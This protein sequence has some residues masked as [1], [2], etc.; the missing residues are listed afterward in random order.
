MEGLKFDLRIYVLVY[1]CDPYRIYM[2][3]EGLARLATEKYTIPKNANI[4]NA[5]M[6][7]TN[8]AINKNNECF[9][10][11][12][13]EDKSEVGHKRSLEFLW[14]YI[15]QQGGNAEDVKEKIKRCIVKVFC[16]VQPLLAH[17]Y[18][19]CQPNDFANNKCFEILG[20]DILLDHKLKPWLLEVNQAPSFKTDTPLDKKVKTELLVD[21]FRLIRLD[22]AKRHKYYKKKNAAQQMCLKNYK[23]SRAKLMKEERE[24]KKAKKMAKRD[25][26]EQAHLGNFELIYPNKDLAIQYDK[27]ICIATDLWESFTGCRKKPVQAPTHIPAKKCR[28]AVRRSR[29]EVAGAKEVAKC[30]RVDVRGKEGC[31]VG[32]GRASHSIAMRVFLDYLMPKLDSGCANSYSQIP[33]SR[34]NY[35]KTQGDLTL[36]LYNLNNTYFDANQNYCSAMGHTNSFSQPEYPS[37]R[38]ATS[39]NYGLYVVPQMLKLAK[40]NFTIDFRMPYLYKRKTHFYRPRSHLK[41]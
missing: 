32:K 4:K 35:N 16:S 1:G 11:N 23:S 40:S 25:L 3:K 8:Y 15:T 17:I 26:Y 34:P 2:Y 30:G 6:H 31:E 24:Q 9:E 28:P 22:P 38:S 18:K 37:K 7:L 13:G 12:M 10:F 36:S 27:Y 5:Y 33:G 39:L 19:S 29:P 14:L 20:F 21:T 41:Y